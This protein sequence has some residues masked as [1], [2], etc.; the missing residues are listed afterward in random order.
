MD[1]RLVPSVL[2][3]VRAVPCPL[4][5]PCSF[6]SYFVSGRVTNKELTL[7]MQRRPRRDIRSG[8]HMD[9]IAFSICSPIQY[10][11]LHL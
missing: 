6:H 4:P 7:F 1:S 11:P 5:C 9:R 10:A 8:D 2:F 3:L